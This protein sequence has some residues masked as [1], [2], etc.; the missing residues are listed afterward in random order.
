MRAKRRRAARGR[1]PR[2]SSHQAQANISRALISAALT[3]E[4]ATLLAPRL[5]QDLVKKD[6]S[7][8]VCVYVCLCVCPAHAGVTTDPRVFP[9]N[10]ISEKTDRAHTSSFKLAVFLRGI[11][12]DFSLFAAARRSQ[13]GA[14]IFRAS[15]QVPPMSGVKGTT[16]RES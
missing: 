16:V 12:T 13:N 14:P 15:L 3:P 9:P 1:V 11:H 6:P 7:V 8:R 4:G 2:R 5:A 10:K